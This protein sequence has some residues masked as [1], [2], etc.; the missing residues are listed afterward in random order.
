MASEG[1]GIFFATLGKWQFVRNWCLVTTRDERVGISGD[2]DICE[3]NRIPDHADY[4][5]QTGML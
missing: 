1:P 2:S 3:L 4:N 5:E